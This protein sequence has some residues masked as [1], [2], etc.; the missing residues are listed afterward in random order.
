MHFA[1]WGNP[2]KTTFRWFL[3]VAAALAPAGPLFAGDL[4]GEPFLSRFV[5][6]LSRSS[7]FAASGGQQASVGD[8]K[9]SS[10]NPASDAFSMLADPYRLTTTATT[11][12]AFSDSGAWLMTYAATG[13]YHL[14]DAG[15]VISLAYARTD[16]N[17]GET[18]IGQQIVLRSNEFFFGYSRKL[19]DDLAVGV[20]GRF[21]DA[22]LDAREPGP[23]V[24]AINHNEFDLES[25]DGVIG[26]LWDVNDQWSLGAT[27]S[28]SYAETILE[29]RNTTLIF[30]PGIPPNTLL[31]RT[32]DAA[33]ARGAR[34]GA[35]W[36]AHEQLTLYG[37]V[38][39]S[40]VDSN[41]S[42]ITE[43]GRAYVGAQWQPIET[44][45]L[46]SGVS[47]DTDEQAVIAAGIGYYGIEDL[48]LEFSYQYNAAPE[49]RQEFGKFHILTLSLTARF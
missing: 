48:A 4:D 39:Y 35:A 33:R 23:P 16:T 12:Q 28:L 25:Y 49:V 20:R 2:V 41:F 37:D 47:I 46:R 36:R 9:G 8:S 7:N 11:I 24:G 18:R 29:T 40:A 31:L 42:G 19:A 15:G 26:V 1:F 5:L 17:D 21:T 10:A 32:P 14:P 22:Q 27:G 13:K 38:E 43:V 44:I 30:P 3:V 34:L 6:S 45:Y